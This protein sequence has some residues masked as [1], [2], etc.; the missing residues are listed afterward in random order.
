MLVRGGR[1]AILGQFGVGGSGCRRQIADFMSHG[2]DDNARSGH[3]GIQAGVLA[4]AQI[5]RCVPDHR[6]QAKSIGSSVGGK[7]HVRMKRLSA[8]PLPLAFHPGAH[9]AAG[10]VGTEHALEDRQVGVDGNA[11]ERLPLFK[12]QELACRFVRQNHRTLWIER[13]NR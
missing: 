2:A 13:E 12:A 1:T 6:G 10:A 8:A 11:C 7:P 9:V 4:V 3:H 5:L